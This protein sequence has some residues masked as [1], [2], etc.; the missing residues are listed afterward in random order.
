MSN[1]KILLVGA[2]ESA[3]FDQPLRELGWKV[4]RVDSLAA[5]NELQDFALVIA[6]ARALKEC[7]EE[8][9]WGTDKPGPKP[10]LVVSLKGN[11]DVPEWARKHIAGCVAPEVGRTQFSTVLRGVAARMRQQA[12]A[13]RE[14]PAT[15]CPELMGSSVAAERL[16]ETVRNLSRTHAAVLIHGE[17]GTAKAEVAVAL[18]RQSPWCGEILWRVDCATSAD[19][20]EADL[21]GKGPDNPGRLQIA[22]GGSLILQEVG[23][24]SVSAQEKLMEFFRSGADDV[25]V[26]ATTSDDL[27]SACKAGTFREELFLRLNIGPISISPLRERKSDVRELAEFLRKQSGSACGSE[28]VA[29]SPAAYEALEGYAWPGN[30]AELGHVIGRAVILASAEPLIEP[31]HL[32]LGA[33]SSG[34]CSQDPGGILPLDEVERQHIFRA[35]ERCQWNR[36]HAAA[37]LGISIRTL[38]NKLREYRMASEVAGETS[39][40]EAA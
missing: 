36:T 4:S 31:A 20:L 2:E 13:G 14:H 26:F 38:R 3:K 21:F 29:F 9:G 1:E 7:D 24:L 34:I 10:A 8:S 40:Q 32:R 22:E 19:T 6:D 35:L 11:D 12:W 39:E 18:H 37:K 23:R 27:E 25:R 5:T 33:D 17:A 30:L 15:E 16:R 28:A